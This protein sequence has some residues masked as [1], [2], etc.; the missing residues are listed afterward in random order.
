MERYNHRDI[1]KHWQATW[2]NRET[3]RA[4][5]DF[6]KDKYYVLEMFPYPSG[7]IHMGHVRNYTMGDVVARYKRALGYNVLHP[8]GWDAFGMPA[9]NAAIQNN[10]HPAKWTYHNISNMRDQLK[11][12]GLSIDWTKEIATCDPE[13][14][15]HEQKL[16]LDF[17]KKGLVSRK[18]SKVNWDPVDHTVLA[19]E[20]VIEGKGW[21]SG[22]T[23]EIR[24]L[25]Q[26]FFNITNYAEDLIEKL[27]TLDKWPEKVKIMQNHWIGKSTGL[28]FKFEIENS[29]FP[30]FDT[31]EVFTTRPDTLFGASFVAIAADHPIA[32]ELEKIGNEAEKFIKECR[33]KGTTLAEIEKAEKMG[34]NTGIQVKH[35]FM[36]NTKLDIFIA[37]FVLMEYGTG[38]IFGCP[39]HDQRDLDF[40]R[41]YDLGVTP[42]VIPDN[43]TEEN[44]TINEVAYT[45]DGK[46]FNSQFLNGLS[47]QEAKDTVINRMLEN[48]INKLPQGTP[49]ITYRLR[50]WGISRQ[51]Y[52]GCPIPVV[53]CKKCGIVEVHI[54]N[55]PVRLPDDV[56]F[57][58]PGNP[59]ERHPTW[60]HTEC[61]S[62][63]GDAIRE[64]DTFDTFVDSSW[65]FARF[66]SPKSGDPVDT[67]AVNYWLPVDQ[68]IGG[69]EHAIL[70]LLYSRFFTRAMKESNYVKLEEPFA[71]LFTQG[72]VT[73]ETYKDHDG[74]WIFP[75]EVIYEDGKPIHVETGKPVTVGQIESMSKSKKNI[76]DPQNIVE[77]YG[78][79][80]A[81]WFILSDT[82]PERDIQWTDKGVEAS[83]KFIQKA[84]KLINDG[85]SKLPKNNQNIPQKFSSEAIEIRKVT[86]RAISDVTD[87]L[88]NL[89]FNRAIAHVYELSNQIQIIFSENNKYNDISALYAKR[90]CLETYC[91]LFSP[92]APHLAE[93]CWKILECS[94]IIAEKAW[95]KLIKEYLEEEEVLI[96]VQVNG[97]KRGVI[98]IPKDT[99]RSTIEDEAL[100]LDNVKKIIT[101]EIKKIIY[102]PNRIINVVI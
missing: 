26:W 56:D 78:A 29:P 66:C 63:K 22:A 53:H 79:D 91:Q 34:F 45:G 70:H 8:M 19:N 97:K 62:C 39:A 16:F 71:G 21:R 60:K 90:E 31:L 9:E 33:S 92:M 50:D 86:H 40:A 28:Q 57:N 5:D 3:F 93:E 82:P 72:M 35:P 99:N 67:D 77:T 20:Q 74:K 81:R 42:V 59:L 98:M 23:V 75:E 47:I 100:A 52:W 7:K 85:K 12:L 102:V 95:P 32:K 55:L 84:W 15:A 17:Y 54:E 25:T 44:F 80:T 38:A 1:E 46:I 6:S 30:E 4:S 48:Q 41:K 61:P 88:D 49:K 87:A 76:I 94:D 18:K 96:I 69:V 14:Y 24:E 27:Q 36:E 58:N 13:Y 11:L 68:Y 64:T 101:S 2:E 83:S 65:Y 43:E 51:R 37:N 73:H 10:V 89:R